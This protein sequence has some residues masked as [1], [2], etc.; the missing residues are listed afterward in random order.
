MSTMIE[1]V[2]R[3]ICAATPGTG[4]VDD[5]FA[6]EHS[7]AR[8]L[9]LKMAGAAIGAIRLQPLEWRDPEPPN[10]TCRYDHTITETPFGRVIIEW[11]SWKSYP[12]YSA[13]TPWDDFISED[14]LDEAKEAVRVSLEQRVRAIL[15]GANEGLSP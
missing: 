9:W 7:A 2:A 1:R 14:T 4:C 11:K 10:E 12:G 3:A 15:C 8:G 5:H 6:D 13:S